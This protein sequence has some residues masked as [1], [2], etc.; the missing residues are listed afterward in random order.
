MVWRALG[1]FG[2]LNPPRCPFLPFSASFLRLCYTVLCL[3][4]GTR[5]R[6]FSLETPALSLCFLHFSS[7]I[8]LFPTE[9]LLATFLGCYHPQSL[10]GSMSLQLLVFEIY[11]QLIFWA[12]IGWQ[13]ET[14]MMAKPGSWHQ[15]DGFCCSCRFVPR[16]YI[17]CPR[18]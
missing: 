1:V 6:T 12:S 15:E 2:G 7:H 14:P 13:A 11:Y 3:F 16:E 9:V 5:T 8:L 18:S 17:H 10:V 4:P